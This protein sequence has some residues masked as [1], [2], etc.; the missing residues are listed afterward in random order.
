MEIKLTYILLFLWV[1]IGC[2]LTNVIWVIRD[3]SEGD[4]EHYSSYILGMAGWLLM[5]PITI[6]FMFREIKR[7]M[8]QKRKAK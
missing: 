1:F 2:G 4:K 8:L 7:M 5:G 6:F 3:M